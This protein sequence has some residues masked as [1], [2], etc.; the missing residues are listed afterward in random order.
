MA[1]NETIYGKLELDNLLEALQS[2]QTKVKS[3]SNWQLQSDLDQI[4]STYDNM[5]SFFSKGVE[6]TEYGNM[7]QELKRKAYI[8]NDLANREIRIKKHP[9]EQFCKVYTEFQTS[10][11]DM[12]TLLTGLSTVG[13]QITRLNDNQDTRESV[14]QH[15]MK[16]LLTQ[17]DTLMERLFNGIWVSDQWTQKEYSECLDILKDLSVLP[18][19]KAM[20]VSAVTLATF[21]M[22]DTNKIMFLF[23]AYLEDAPEISQRSLTGLLLLIIRYNRREYFIRQITPRFRIYSEN[24]QFVEDCFRVLMQLQYSKATDS[25]SLKMTQDILPTLMKSQNNR[26]NAKNFEEELTKQGENPEWHHRLNITEQAE[27]KM[28]QMTEMQMDG[29]DVYWNTFCHLKHFQF[30]K[31]THHWFAP[32]TDYYTECLDAANNLRQEILQA[33]DILFTLSTFCDSD[34]FSFMLMLSTMARS[35]QDMI[36]NQIQSQLDSEGVMEVYKERKRKKAE[37]QAVSKSYIYDLYRFFKSNPNHTQFFD[38]FNK[39][40]GDFNP[41]DFAVLNGLVTEE[42][43]NEILATAEFMMRKERYQSAIALFNK[44]EPKEREEDTD[45]WQKIGFCHQKDK[46]DNEAIRHYEVADRLKPG[47]RWTLIH[48]AQTYMSASRY[49]QAND[50][51]DEILETEPENLKWIRHKVDCLFRLNA[52]EESIHIL[53]KAAYLDEE[54][55]QIKAMLGRALYIRG[56]KEKAEHMLTE[57]TEKEPRTD[58]LTHLAFIHYLRGDHTEAYRLFVKAYKAETQ[59][60]TFAPVFWDGLSY[61]NIDEST[62][63]KERLHLMFDAVRTQSL[64]E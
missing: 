58:N 1:N 30:F 37:A 33:N 25:V 3:L 24:R 61:F 59:E 35:A 16:E 60:N 56:D 45:I 34:K 53:Y 22:L 39:L 2:L 62:E 40:L 57:L 31:K 20:T 50:T 47:S 44:L 64:K 43:Y 11:L 10:P 52:F 51:I 55:T 46:N 49:R 19:A 17:H 7:R 6:D 12:K 21:E 4:S 42:N 8:I 36:A 63:E 32:F 41:L 26:L 15:Q 48:L 9:Y 28:R 5:L 29:A 27:K 14:R 54:S 38:P 18:Q 23:D 13:D